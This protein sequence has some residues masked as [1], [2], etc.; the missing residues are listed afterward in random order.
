[1][2][3]PVHA[4]VLGVALSLL[5]TTGFA[6]TIEQK[7]QPEQTLSAMQSYGVNVPT[8]KGLRSVVPAGWR[9]Y[10]HQSITL[11][12]SMS[13][14]PGESWITVVGEVADRCHAVVLIDWQEKAVYLRTAEVALDQGAKEAELR[15]AAITPLPRFDTSAPAQAAARTAIPAPAS[16]V[17]GDSAVASVA[18]PAPSA[19]V[20]GVIASSKLSSPATA[21]AGP[22]TSSVDVAKT[23]AP[24]ETL[25][26]EH[27]PARP[28][29]QVAAPGTTIAAQP[30]TAV[31]S[32]AAQMAAALTS[33]PAIAPNPAPVAPVVVAQPPLAPQLAPTL[34]PAETPRLS[35]STDFEYQAPVALNQPQARV[36]AQGIANR[37]HLRLVWLAPDIQLRGPVTLLGRSVDEDVALLQKALGVYAPVAFDIP[38]GQGVLAV[39]SLEG[40]YPDLAVNAPATASVA[41]A[42][43]VR[44]VLPSATHVEPVIPAQAQAPIERPRA[45][46]PV[47]AA[48]PVSAADLKVATVVVPSAASVA[49]PTAAPKPVAEAS[50]L[51]LTADTKVPELELTLHV[52]QPLEVAIAQFAESQAYTV[53]WQVAGGFKAKRELTYHGKTVAAVL[54]QVLPAL[55]VSADINTQEKHIVV[56][57]ADPLRDL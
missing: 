53:D 4:L 47:Q 18:A 16:S 41:I 39:H 23:L 44:D 14:K 11:P 20:A 55:G 9:T 10:V 15:Q 56:R 24:T 22:S 45:V 31:S 3:R 46:V 36:V 48:A 2:T 7:G 26:S 25:V 34:L 30:K 17:A 28:A 43:P 6:S 42:A 35:A 32:G 50:Q 12:D 49:A 29:D 37:F 8:E 33:V 51:L 1:M 40:N 5:G 52:G 21:G 27:P 38:T 19:P 57:P 54:S 13:W